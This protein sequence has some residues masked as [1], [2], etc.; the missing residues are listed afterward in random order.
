M[1]AEAAA[2]GLP[3]GAIVRRVPAQHDAVPY[4]A[5]VP[6]TAGPR[7]PVLVTVH[8]LSRNAGDHARRFAP[9]CDRYGV[10]LAAPIFAPGLHDDY[11][12]LGRSGR[13]RRADLA[14]DAVLEDLAAASGASTARIHLFGFSGGAQFAHRYAMAHP[15]RV[16]RAAVAAAGWYT[17]PDES[18]VYPYGIAPSPDARHLRFEPR[19]FLRVPIAVLVGARDT[20]DRNLRLDRRLDRQQG[21]TRVE[22][23]RR[24]AAAMQAA[25]RAQGLEPLVTFEEVPDMDHSFARFVEEGRLGE[26]VFE[27]LFG[28]QPG[29]SRR[30]RDGERPAHAEASR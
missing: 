19:Q 11:Q 23:A 2:Q 14:L 25:A 15:Q 4:L 24:W 9:W 26:R 7:A 8:G 16:A 22:R 13:G 12:R 29:M 5:Y 6:E 27:A 3:R 10:V 30:E 21:T 17:F 20:G 18:T 1:A 28:A